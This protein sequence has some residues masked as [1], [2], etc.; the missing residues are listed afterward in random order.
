MSHSKNLCV[1]NTAG[2]SALTKYQL[3]KTWGALVV[4][5]AA[6]DAVVGV[7]TDGC[8]ASSP[9]NLCV[10][11]ETFAIASAAIAAGAEI[12]PA[13]SGKVA[14]HTGTNVKVGRVIGDAA[15][16]DGDIVRILLY[17]NK[18]D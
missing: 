15:T 2:A 6:T 11:G 14:T 3:V 16:A 12:Q 13:A 8:D 18:A 10:S 1:G 4:S 17:G 5:A 9:V 7:V